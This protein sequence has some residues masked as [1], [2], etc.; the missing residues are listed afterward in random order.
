MARLCES[1]AGGTVTEL[2][3]TLIHEAL[4]AR[5]LR[6]VSEVEGAPGAQHLG[7][8]FFADSLSPLCEE[9]GAMRRLMAEA[10]SPAA[11]LDALQKMQLALNGW[12]HQRAHDRQTLQ[13]L[14]ALIVQ[15]LGYSMMT[16]REARWLMEKALA[17]QQKTAEQIRQALAELEA[18]SQQETEQAVFKILREHQLAE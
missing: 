15:A 4:R 6:A 14:Y 1:P 13:A 2:A 9:L 11:P 7:R 8:Q 12:Q 5:R 3:R 17:A 18:Q 10:P 16:E